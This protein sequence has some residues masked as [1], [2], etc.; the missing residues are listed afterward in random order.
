MCVCVQTPK[1]LPLEAPQSAGTS[2]I[3]ARMW[4]EYIEYTRRKGVD[5]TDGRLSKKDFGELVRKL[6]MHS[7]SDQ[8][9]QTIFKMADQDYSGAVDWSEFSNLLVVNVSNE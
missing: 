7:L 5:R 4:K 8:N 2:F 1:Y 9:V 6:G 3:L